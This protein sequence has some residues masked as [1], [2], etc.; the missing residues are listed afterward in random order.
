MTKTPRYLD[1]ANQLRRA[2]VSDTYPIGS[3]IPTELE[4][5]KKHN[6][7][8]HT[9]RAALQVLDDEDLIE[10]RPGLG[11]TV[12]SA[13]Q[14]PAFTQPLGGL[15]KLLQYAHDAILKIETRDHCTL[16]S[17]EAT[18]LKA[19]KESAWHRLQGIRVKDNHPLAIT[20][21]YVAEFLNIAAADLSDEKLAI[22]EQLEDLTGISVGSIEQ[23]IGATLL[24][25]KNSATLE[26][27]S[28]SAAL[29]TVRRYY[30]QAGRLF[31]I[32]DS[33]HPADRFLYEMTYKRQN[34]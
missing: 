23:S 12:I 1:L 29:R 5:C 2:I 27:Q 6:V 26:A 16:N 11:T 13:G 19:S 8:R 15:D 34:D 22:T 21:I 28:G 20:T 9:A 17:N 10:R 33:H 24:T 14:P 30:D 7:S 32:S 25:E 31:V 3:Q 18:F 4:L